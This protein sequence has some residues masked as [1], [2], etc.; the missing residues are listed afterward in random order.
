MTAD[1]ANLKA[2]HL[3][4]VDD[5][6]LVLSVISTG[7]VD[8]GFEVTTAETAEDAEAWLAGGIRPDLAVLDIHM[9]GQGGLFLADR[10]RALDHIPF[11]MFSAY[12][13]PAMVEQASQCGALGFLVKPLDTVQ[14]VPAIEA[15][16]ARADELKDLRTTQLQ[17]QSALDGER[18]ISIAIGITMMQH[19]LKR[20]E[21]FDSLRTSARKRRCKLSELATEVIQAAEKLNL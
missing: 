9:P 5:D 18:D 1:K 10:L 6:R 20:N 12:S 17:L 19:R 8:A 7:M 13:D 14:L 2:R 21:A 3:L 4:L 15:A 16:L 11:M